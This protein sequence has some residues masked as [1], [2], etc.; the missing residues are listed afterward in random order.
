MRLSADHLFHF[1][2]IH[3]IPHVL[4][5]PVRP[6]QQKDLTFFI[7]IPVISGIKP[8][9]AVFP[10]HK[11]I[12]LLWLRTQISGAYPDPV[13]TQLTRLTGC[14]RIPVLI[15]RRNLR[16][17]SRFPDC[18]RSVI[19]PG[20]FGCHKPHVRYSIQVNDLSSGAHSILHFLNQR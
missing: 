5:Q 17:G 14:K 11:L 7:H 6:S 15:H 9:D 8:V 16:A 1:D 3:T 10:V 2:A 4:D 19:L 12:H 20:N 13:N 18:V